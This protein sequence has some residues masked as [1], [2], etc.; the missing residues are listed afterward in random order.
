M[1]KIW[2]IIISI[3]LVT[4]AFTGC[5]N[6]A[7]NNTNN[8]NTEQKSLKVGVTAGPH[9]E[10]IQKV[11]EVAKK[12]GLNIE[13]V[14][15]NDYVQPNVQL[16]EKQLDVNIYQHEPFLKQFNKDHKMNLVKVG[17]AVNFPMGVYSNKIKSL[18]DLKNGDKISVPNDPT[19]EARALLLFQSAKVIKL[20]DGVGL[21]ATV[22][23]V[24]ENPKG[25]QF[26]E[27]E[28]PMVPRSL[29]DVS[30]AAI[31]TNYALQANLNPSKDAIFI[32]PK[33]SPWINIIV[34]REDNKNDER[35]QKLIQAYHSDEVKKFIEE[36]FKGSVVPAF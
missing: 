7:A 11:K 20:K 22:K 19:N 14:S 31:N 18:N 34:A 29:A 12:Q 27:L 2:T 13:V 6:K 35:I 1:K 33:D 10:I 9:E 36:H 24:V 4:I 15:F 26:L 5:G 28:A 32:E 17:D 25:I 21:K 16:N 23:D 30:C 8:A 3:L